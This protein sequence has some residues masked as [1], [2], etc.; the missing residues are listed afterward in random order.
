MCTF[1][2]LNL[3]TVKQTSIGSIL[4]KAK[5]LAVNPDHQQ[6]KPNRPPAGD[7][8][9][10]GKLLSQACLKHHLSIGIAFEPQN[11]YVL[12]GKKRVNVVLDTLFHNKLCICSCMHFYTL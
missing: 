10:D 4:Q 3:K 11:R 7:G 8:F 1:D 2:A 12:C 9:I 5:V 6:M